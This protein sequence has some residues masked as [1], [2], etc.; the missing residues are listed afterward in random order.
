MIHSVVGLIHTLAAVVALVTGLSIFFRRK[1]GVI[2]RTLGYVYSVSMLIMLVTAF[3][4]YRL[5]NSFNFL[6]G[7]ALLST[8]Q[9]SRGFYFAISRQPKR[10]WL[11]S[12]YEWMCAS[13]IG[14]VAAFVAETSVRI[15]MPYL[16]NSYGVT[17]FGWF[18]ALV[19][20]ATFVVVWIGQILMQRNRASLKGYANS[21]PATKDTPGGLP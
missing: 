18:W 3:S 8:F 7:F 5:T 4:I 12:H 2:H 9:L 6:H 21:L 10:A 11:D 1:V 15:L 13:Y 14:L 16:E 17:S 19:G 20:I